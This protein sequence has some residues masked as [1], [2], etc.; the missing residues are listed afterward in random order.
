MHSIHHGICPK[1]VA[2]LG[3][4]FFGFLMAGSAFAGC[5][6]RPGT[7]VDM[8]AT[9]SDN[10][11]QLDF[12]N[13]AT[14]A[15]IYWDIEVTDGA[16]HGLPGGVAGVR[17]TRTQATGGAYSELGR[18]QL[19]PIQGANYNANTTYCFR[20]R[21]RTA[22][23]TKGCVSKLWNNPV[24]VTTP[25][26]SV[27]Q[28]CST[29][30]R[31][32]IN[33]LNYLRNVK[34]Q[35]NCGDEGA[36]WNSNWLDHYN[37]CIA[38]RTKPQSAGAPD[39]ERNERNKR[40]QVC[41]GYTCL[42]NVCKQIKSTGKSTTTPAP[43]KPAT[44]P[45]PSPNPCQ[46][47]VWV[48]NDECIN[49]DGT[50]MTSNPAGALQTFGCGAT[51]DE[52]LQRAKATFHIEGGPLLSD[53]DKPCPG[54]CTYKKKVSKICV[55]PIRTYSKKVGEKP[56]LRGM[57]RTAAGSCRCPAG[58]RWS[59]SWCRRYGTV[60]PAATPQ[61][62]PPTS[63]GRSTPTSPPTTTPCPASRPVGTPP[64]CCPA[65]TVFGDGV[66]RQPAKP[67]PGSSSGA[68]GGSTTTS[69]GDGGRVCPR[70]RPIGTFPHCCPMGMT[71]RGHMCR[72]DVPAAKPA[73]D[74]G[75]S[76]STSKE[77]GGTCPRSRPVGTPP[78]CC[79]AG[80]VFANGVCRQIAK[81][82]PGSSGDGATTTSGGGGTG[83]ICPRSRPVGTFPHCCP[84]GMTFRGHMCRRDVPAAKP[85][86]DGGASTST[87][88]ETGGTCPRSRPVGTPPHCCPRG[89]SFQNGKCVH[90]TT[91]QPQPQ[92][93]TQT[94]STTQPS[95]AKCSGGRRGI[96]PNCFCAGGR[97]FI[98]GRCRSIPKPKPTPTPSKNDGG[99]I[100]K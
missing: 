90:P 48:S 91:T 23:G 94:P 14:E 11:I 41:S 3:A 71:Y 6:D 84:K 21:A 72:Y 98:G 69:G 54:C 89:T 53:G 37:W 56:C 93:Q 80:T 79:P 31:D 30:A 77:T 45:A 87:S 18:F 34:Y 51:E 97:R 15:P 39:F 27:N 78:N 43:P 29:Y 38:V 44:P 47:T 7:P 28:F 19:I 42:N 92:T 40:L 70:S 74:G 99:V 32:A 60:T 55:C 5:G 12:T 16:G 86:G 57:I 49:G 68:D 82:T 62:P 50:P 10:Q 75:A 1:L 26:T 100:V 24:C 76:T 73:G 22:G 81:P 36:R 20:V 46:Y 17:G 2:A 58:S 4:G 52:A 95:K 64:N 66:C 8:T 59:G 35:G 65:G 85:G 9:Q 67:T 33:Q 61:P 25:D 13:T 63:P 88:K 83:G 96:P